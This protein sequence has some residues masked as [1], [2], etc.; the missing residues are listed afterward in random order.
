MIIGAI[1]I[2]TNLADLLALIRS[3]SSF[4]HRFVPS[5][6][7]DHVILVGNFDVALL[8]D[9]F[10]EFFCDDHGNRTMRTQLVLLNPNEPSEELKALM[11]DPVYSNRVRYVKGSTLS[12]RS[13]QKVSAS[14]AE[15]VFVLGNRFTQEDPA[16]EDA[17]LVMRVLVNCLHLVVVVFTRDAI[18]VVSIQ[19]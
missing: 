1:F 4:D 17:R 18:V 12:T 5:S 7:Q 10:R 11:A 9:F 3:K 6:R 13:L 2:P 15:A 14:S 16:E 19:S 8:A